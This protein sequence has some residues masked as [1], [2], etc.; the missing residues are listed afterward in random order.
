MKKKEYIVPDV[1]GAACM[2][3]SVILAASVI[4]MSTETD[5]VTVEPFEPVQSS[6]TTD[7]NSFEV[8]FE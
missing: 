2:P 1:I 3:S 4:K 7:P 5:A 8:T 6:S